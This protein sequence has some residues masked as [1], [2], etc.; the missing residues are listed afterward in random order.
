VDLVARDA[1]DYPSPRYPIA[2]ARALIV[3]ERGRNTCREFYA[4]SS[5]D[6]FQSLP[7]AIAA[8]KALNS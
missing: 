1:I 2:F 5:P 7:D 4:I 6:H 3:V 8:L